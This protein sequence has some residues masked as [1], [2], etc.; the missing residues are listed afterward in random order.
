M[1]ISDIFFLR[2]T[3]S[4]FESELTKYEIKTKLMRGEKTSN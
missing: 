3:I 4:M 1:K 2:L